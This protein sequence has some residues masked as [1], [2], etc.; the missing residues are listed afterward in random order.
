MSV[1]ALGYFTHLEYHSISLGREIWVKAKSNISGQRY[2]KSSS[3]LGPL[4][5]EKKVQC[6]YIYRCTLGMLLSLKALQYIL[7]PLSILAGANDI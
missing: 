3:K 4:R 5:K 7:L 2:P 6:N 1:L